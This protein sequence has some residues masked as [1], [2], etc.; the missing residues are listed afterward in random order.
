MSPKKQYRWI[1]DV[2]L[3]K[4]YDY[5]LKIGLTPPGENILRMSVYE[6]LTPYIERGDRILDIGC[7]TGTLTIL[8]SN[9]LFSNCELIG[10]DLSKGQIA[11]ARKKN[12]NS[13]LRFEV[14]DARNLKFKNESFDKVIISAVLHEMN[15][16]ERLIVLK[17][18]NRIL[19]KKGFF[20]IFDH[21]EPSKTSLR[22]YYNFYLGFWEKI[23]S[24]SFE[25][26]RNILN[27][28][29]IAGF[30]VISQIPIEKF[31]NFFQIILSQK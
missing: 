31:R 22:I 8:L 3:S 9:L 25:M 2:I 17:E 15:K 14:M 4:L 23:F 30:N 20:L 13:I 28:L 16:I 24:H 18:V 26:Q 5:G 7:G 6:V 21:H 10:I 12:Y 19:K 11:Q 29:K 27:E 1:Y